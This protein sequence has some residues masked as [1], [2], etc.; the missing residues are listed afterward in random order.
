MDSKSNESKEEVSR[1]ITAGEAGKVMIMSGGQVG[2]VRRYEGS[3]REIKGEEVEEV[4]KG[5]LVEVR[6]W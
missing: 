4:R 5:G 1:E 6:G 3:V 2:K